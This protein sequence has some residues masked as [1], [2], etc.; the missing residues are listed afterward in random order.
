[1]SQL[2][3]RA[4]GAPLSEAEH[5]QRIDAARSRWGAAATA[6]ATAAG[7]ALAGAAA[8]RG[9][10]ALRANT[11]ARLRAAHQPIRAENARSAT[12]LRALAAREKSGLSAIRKWPVP[13]YRAMLAH[14]IHTR[15]R[16]LRAMPSEVMGLDPETGADVR[17]PVDQAEA[18]RVAGEIDQRRAHLERLEEAVPPKRVP[19]KATRAKVPRAHTRTIK[20]KNREDPKAREVALKDM[21]DRHAAM[22]AQMEQAGHEP[23]ELEN[24]RARFASRLERA[25]GKSQRVRTETKVVQVGGDRTSSQQET[26]RDR[27]SGTRRVEGTPGDDEL[28]QMRSEMTERLRTKL[29][30]PRWREAGRHLDAAR[31]VRTQFRG[32][33]SPLV[34]WRLPGGNVRRGLLGAAVGLGALGGFFGAR[35][36]LGKAAD[37]MQGQTAQP[38]VADQLAAHGVAAEETM[39]ERLANTFRAWKDDVAPGLLDGQPDGEPVSLLNTFTEGLTHATEPMA[40][41]M[42]AGADATVP[43]TQD[44]PEGPIRTLSFN[45]GQ[46]RNP[47]VEAYISTYRQN[48]IA[49]LAAEQIEA[50][51]NQLVDAARTG[52]SPQEMARRIRGSIG[53]TANQAQQVANYRA[54]LGNLSGAALQ[55]QLRDK[56]YDRTVTR[57]IAEAKQLTA[58]QVDDMVDAYHRRYLAYR[59]T[60]IARTEGV[61][62]ANNGHMAALQQVLDANTE[63]VVVK[64]WNAKLDAVTRPDHVALNGQT[65]VGF[66]TPFV[67]PSGE[68]AR[69]PGDQRASA[70][71]VINCRCTLSTRLVPRSMAS[72]FMAD[73]PTAGVSDG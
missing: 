41:A 32:A 36:A 69:W 73:D 7:G 22:L 68:K 57:A 11:L 27:A 67:A 40:T 44:D 51:T 45:L 61:G 17:G 2:E 52:A 72:Q 54:E 29:R 4:A 23:W 42:R 64:E 49:E 12:V 65:V 50:V 20:V 34:R 30:E 62:A 16:G 48:K 55:R 58:K 53:L 46:V 5:Q 56:R 35:Q 13:P 70:K 8:H 15:V 59:A 66:D 37:D 39:A 9:I 60:T 31:A 10:A 6:A 14:D 21:A 18:A 43:V 33:A 1:M 71:M 28:K 3:K 63:M 24:A 26:K 19:F 38:S 47:L 25:R